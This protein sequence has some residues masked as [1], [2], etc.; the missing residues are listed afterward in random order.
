MNGAELSRARRR[1]MAHETRGQDHDGRL[2]ATYLTLDEAAA[3]MGL[4]KERVRQIE[5]T[6]LWKMRKRLGPYIDEFVDS[7]WLSPQLAKRIKNER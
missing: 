7:G 6:A 5:R 2:D 3:V 1:L 4:S